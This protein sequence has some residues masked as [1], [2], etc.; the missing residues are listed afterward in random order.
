MGDL[1]AD[2][3]EEVA[4]RLANDRQSAILE[5]EFATI[6]ARNEVE[7]HDVEAF[8]EGVRIG[9]WWAATRASSKSLEIAWRCSVSGGEW[10]LL[11]PLRQ[12]IIDTVR[13][14]AEGPALDSQGFTSADANR[15]D[16]ALLNGWLVGAAEISAELRVHAAAMQD[17]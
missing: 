15:L 16:A 7:P 5:A 4:E 6:H 9:R 11:D 13:D 2:E 3:L 1:S 17:A 12:E 8:R 14:D 10:D